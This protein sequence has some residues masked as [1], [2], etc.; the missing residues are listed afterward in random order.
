MKQNNN[1]TGYQAPA[2]QKAFQLLEFVSKSDRGG[3]YQ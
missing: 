1:H 3:R 2:V